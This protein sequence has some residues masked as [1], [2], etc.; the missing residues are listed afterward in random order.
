M[1]GT[2]LFLALFILGVSGPAIAQD[3]PGP[4]TL[5]GLKGVS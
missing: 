1:R 3:R 2:F 5:G 4:A